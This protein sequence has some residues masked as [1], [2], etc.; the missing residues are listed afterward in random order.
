MMQLLLCR[1][2]PEPF[3]DR[4]QPLS[5]LPPPALVRSPRSVLIVLDGRT[6][7][8]FPAGRRSAP[9]FGLGA[10]E[11]VGA[12]ALGAGLAAGGFGAVAAFLAASRDFSSSATCFSRPSMLVLR[13]LFSASRAWS[14]PL[15]EAFSS[16]AV[17]FWAFRASFSFWSS[18]PQPAI[19]KRVR[20]RRLPAIHCVMLCSM[21]GIPV[22]IKFVGRCFAQNAL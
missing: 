21:S 12:G 11:G 9:Y 19:R 7:L 2:G 14:F 3:F 5:R 17:L 20:T 4:L 18:W 16:C 13:V 10:G 6:P 15:R 1:L 8:L 22:G